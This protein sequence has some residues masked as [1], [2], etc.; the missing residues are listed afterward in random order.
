MLEW[1][2]RI[3]KQAEPRARVSIAADVTGFTL[4]TDGH[5]HA[6]PWT[7]V[8]RIAAFKQDLYSHDQIVLLIE[9]TRADTRVLSVP[10]DSP[11]FASLFKPMEEAL[12]IDPSWYLA[13]MTPSFDPT[14]QVLYLRHAEPE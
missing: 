13:I 1:L 12:G 5:T 6:V 14:P 7:A 10:E 2:R 3:T 9:V 11:G 4:T 8:N